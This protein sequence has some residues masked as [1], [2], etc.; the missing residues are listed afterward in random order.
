MES[1]KYDLAIIGM[2]PAGLTAGL[3]ASR[4]RVKNVVIGAVTGGMVSE[5]HRICNY[6]S[7]KEITGAELSRR[8]RENAESQGS[9]ILDDRVSSVKK[10]SG[11]FEVITDMSGA[12]SARSVIIASGMEHRKLGVP[13]EEKFL[14]RGVSYCATCDGMF[15]RNRTVAVIGGSDAALTAALYLSEVASKV[16]I[17]YRGEKL[18]G[19]PVWAEEVM[20]KPNMEIIYGTNVIAM[21]GEKNLQ[22]VKLDK[23]R[24]GSDSLAL[25]GVFVEIGSVPKLDAYEG[26]GLQIDGR[27]HIKVGKDQSTSVTGVFAAGDI[28]DASN[29]FRQIVT[30]MGEGSI[31]A[32]SAFKYLES[33]GGV[34]T[35]SEINVALGA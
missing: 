30:A 5:A 23:P 33:A 29:Y 1:K 32:D 27:G 16:Y 2:G 15:Y 4:Y 25:D 14:G 17:I 20:R 28:T 34:S 11:G 31:A 22:A 26:L 6:P 8:M 9:R 18:R 12:I 21:E 24:S 13:G 3:Y 7:E 10:A 35:E 19:E